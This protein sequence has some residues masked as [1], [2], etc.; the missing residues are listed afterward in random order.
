[1]TGEVEFLE[2]PETLQKKLALASQDI[3]V[4]LSKKRSE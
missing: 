2:L 3:R 1:M 4:H